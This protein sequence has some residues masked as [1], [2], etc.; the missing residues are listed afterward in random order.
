MS[1]GKARSGNLSARDRLRAECEERGAAYPLAFD[2][3]TGTVILCE[4]CPC[5]VTPERL[6]EAAEAVR[7]LE[8]QPGALPPGVYLVWWDEAGFGCRRIALVQ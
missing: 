1:G 2:K 6:D 8:Q 4:R 7:S 5:L 3:L